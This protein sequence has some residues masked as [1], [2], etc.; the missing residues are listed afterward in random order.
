ME[1]SRLGRASVGVGGLPYL[2]RFPIKLTTCPPRVSQTQP[3]TRARRWPH[4]PCAYCRKYR[5]GVEA[6]PSLGPG[7][8]GGPAGEGGSARATDCEN[9]PREEPDGRRRTERRKV[10]GTHRHDSAMRGNMLTLA[11]VLASSI[12]I[13]L[14][15]ESWSAT[16]R[17][18]HCAQIQLG[19]YHRLRC[20]LRNWQQSTHLEDHGRRWGG[21]AGSRCPPARL[22]AKCSGFL[23]RSTSA[24]PIQIRTARGRAL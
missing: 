6:G 24:C 13:L 14:V 15:R 5:Q 18:P 23:S 10:R 20:A 4:A 11:L 22:L 21:N 9:L 16:Y 2:S 8:G 12:T 1:R 19:S 17:C 3:T 7:P